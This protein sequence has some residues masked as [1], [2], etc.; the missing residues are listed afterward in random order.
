MVLMVPQRPMSPMA[1]SLLVSGN[2]AQQQGP[3]CWLGFPTAAA[4]AFVGLSCQLL[5]RF[6]TQL[7]EEAELCCFW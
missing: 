6:S 7:H 1:H 3:L 5:F 2:S 4:V